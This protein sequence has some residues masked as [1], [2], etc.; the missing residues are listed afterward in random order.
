MRFWLLLSLVL[1]TAP[2]AQ[3]AV[4]STL[5]QANDNA[6]DVCRDTSK[7]AAITACSDL[8]NGLMPLSNAQLAEAYYDRGST[9]FRSGN[10]MT[11]L[12]DL[13][14]ALALDSEIIGAYI[15]RGAAHAQTGDLDGAISDFNSALEARPDDPLILV[16]R[17]RTFAAKGDLGHATADVSVA[18][19]VDP[20]FAF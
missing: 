20:R 8:I 17:A 15:I 1:A 3:A 2:A 18:I 19:M 7:L 4:N 11:A 6:W 16:D 14:R 13:D 9:Y 5:P 12:G 10:P